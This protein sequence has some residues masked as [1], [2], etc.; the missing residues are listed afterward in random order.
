M[1]NKFRLI[2]ALVSVVAAVLSVVGVTGCDPTMM[3]GYYYPEYE[4]GYFKY[5]VKT[6]KDGT[7][8][9]YLIGLTESG[10]EQTELIYPEE[11]DGI[12]VYGIGYSIPRI[13]G[14]EHV[15]D[16]NSEN[17]EKFYFPKFPK[18]NLHW[19]S[20][21][22]IYNKFIICWDSTDLNTGIPFIKSAIFSYDFIKKGGIFNQHINAYIAN[23][24]YLYNY[25]NSPNG[26]YYWVDSYNESVITFIP[27][28][29]KREGYKFDGWYKEAECINEWD[30]ET[31]NA[32]AE[33]IIKYDYEETGININTYDGLNL[34]AKWIKV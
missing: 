19:C 1:K 23:V 6:E 4:S 33:I 10:M 17:L 11:I 15:G 34:Y 18:E 2:L 13:P 21:T 9:A 22:G 28:E 24:S 25:E 16:F 29:P 30:F 8:K 26:D 14:Y 27:P 31:D 20:D 7:E 12:T 5:A 3:A 32:G